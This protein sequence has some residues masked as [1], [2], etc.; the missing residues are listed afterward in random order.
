[1]MDLA[2]LAS[3]TESLAKDY[4]TAQNFPE[5]IPKKSVRENLHTKVN[6]ILQREGLL[7]KDLTQE[8]GGNL[9]T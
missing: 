9:G 1:M 4:L 8:T 7:E 2:E 5:L 3:R 6:D